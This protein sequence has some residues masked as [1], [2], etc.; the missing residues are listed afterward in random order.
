MMS[1]QNLQIIHIYIYTYIYIYNIYMLCTWWCMRQ[2]SQTKTRM[3]HPRREMITPCLL[4][5]LNIWEAPTALY[6]HMHY[7]NHFFLGGVLPCE[8]PAWNRNFSAF[9]A[10]ASRSTNHPPQI[11]HITLA[12]QR[13]NQKLGLNIFTQPWEV[14]V[15]LAERFA[16]EWRP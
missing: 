7:I 8:F 1:W 9:P 6:I 5:L 14:R 3:I 10:E 13:R 4:L 12:V 15:Q 11:N 16:K 2:V